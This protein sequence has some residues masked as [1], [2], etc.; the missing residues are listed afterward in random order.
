M[1]DTIGERLERVKR[2]LKE[3]KPKKAKLIVEIEGQ[4]IIR[5]EE[6]TLRHSKAN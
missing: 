1:I 6:N 3:I 5:W 4:T 2:F